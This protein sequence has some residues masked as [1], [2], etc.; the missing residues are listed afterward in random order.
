MVL[1]LL[2]Q[3]DIR[4]GVGVECGLG[5]VCLPFKA[6]ASQIAM[7]RAVVPSFPPLPH[8]SGLGLPYPR[9]AHSRS[10]LTCKKMCLTDG[11][12]P[13][14]GC[15]KVSHVFISDLAR[16]V[17]LLTPGQ[18]GGSWYFHKEGS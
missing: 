4:E 3:E 7:D 5:G 14:P 15:R 2:Q 17:V 9:S 1:G 12:S 8:P 16:A 18:T 6:E 10:L 13:L 11:K